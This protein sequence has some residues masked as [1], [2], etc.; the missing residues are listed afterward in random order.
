M[1]EIDRLVNTLQLEPHPEGGFYK[2]IHRSTTV[3][4]DANGTRKKSA[5]TS[6]YYLLSGN[7]FS[8][9]HRISSD[10]TWYFHLGCD[11]LIYFFD[12]N[13]ILQTIQL[14]HE[15]QNLQAT[16]LANTW[17]AAKPLQQDS[18]SLVSCAVAPGF[19]F[20]DFEIANRAE[21]L[22]EF[23]NSSDNRKAIEM[24]TRV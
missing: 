15:S 11:V 3:V 4:R 7:D 5:L 21:L 6:I 18:F 16:I 10:E 19:E 8:S 20:E 22:R 1:Q 13:Q 23:G 2:E 14:G 24:F 9:W 12:Q 17:F